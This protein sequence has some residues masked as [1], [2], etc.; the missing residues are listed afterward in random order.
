MPR[1]RHGTL[2]RGRLLIYGPVEGPLKLL[3]FP[4]MKRLACLGVCAFL[5]ATAGGGFGRSDEPFPPKGAYNNSVHRYFPDLDAR[6]NAVRY[7]RWRALEIAWVSGID[8]RLDQRFSSYLLALMADAPRY[9]P[10]ADRV[11][12]RVAREAPPVFRA[13]RWGQT[14]EQQVIDILA[15]PDASPRLSADRLTRL[16]DLYRREPWA[17]SEPPDVRPNDDV[18]AAAPVSARI[19]SAGTR[20]FALAAEDLAATDFGQQRWRVRRTVEEF[21][22]T[23]AAERPATDS[24]YRASAPT[25][26][27]RYPS[28]AAHLDRLARFRGEVFLALRG[29]GE[30]IEARRR[31]DAQLIEVARRYRIPAEAIGAR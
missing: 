10:E 25:I 21:D 19:L 7:G 27:D 14:F 9:P 20:L 6:L 29:G 12:P 31:R 30:T 2:R 11:A 4:P 13:L 16:L 17:L 24:M 22:R 28:I 15:S 23:Y 26:L 1:Y 8:R 5:L 3:S 18:I